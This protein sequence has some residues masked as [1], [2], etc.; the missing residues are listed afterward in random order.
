[1]N[2]CMRAIYDVPS[3]GLACSHSRSEKRND[4]TIITDFTGNWWHTTPTTLL[5]KN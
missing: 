3:K 5:K 2:G 4:N 1:M